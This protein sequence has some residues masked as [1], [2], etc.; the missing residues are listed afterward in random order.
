MYFFPT[1]SS[2]FHPV[3]KQNSVPT[4]QISPVRRQTT[5]GVPEKEMSLL[6]ST[7]VRWKVRST[8]VCEGAD[9]RSQDFGFCS[10]GRAQ[11]ERVERGREAKRKGREER[12]RRTSSSSVKGICNAI[13]LG[14][15]VANALIMRRISFFSNLRRSS[16]L[17][18]VVLLA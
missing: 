11:A 14:L 13:K 17:T 15:N 6:S 4:R 1:N 8:K 16:A 3:N 7:R 5:V 9:E 12:E 2:L 18:S 10:M